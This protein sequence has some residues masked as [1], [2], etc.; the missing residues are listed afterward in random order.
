MLIPREHRAFAGLE[1]Q[2]MMF[3]QGN[4]FELWDDGRWSEQLDSWLGEGAV[5]GSDLPDELERLS[6]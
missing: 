3:G 6:Y 4:K 2:A 1:K 5:D